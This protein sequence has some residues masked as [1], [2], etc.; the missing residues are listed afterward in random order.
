MDEK[1]LWRIGNCAIEPYVLG[2]LLSLGG[3]F[4]LGF[5]HKGR[6]RTR[7]DDDDAAA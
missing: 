3:K 4:L 2:G 1:K 7:N 5:D 6:Q